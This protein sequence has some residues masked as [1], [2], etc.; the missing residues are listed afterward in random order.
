MDKR[1]QSVYTA[2]GIIVVLTL[3]IGIILNEVE[4]G[5]G[6]SEFLVTAI[7]LIVLFVIAWGRR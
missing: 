1:G 2:L 7:V 6:N 4:A 5:L 3:T